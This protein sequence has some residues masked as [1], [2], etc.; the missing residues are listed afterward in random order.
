MK[1]INGLCWLLLIIGGLNWGFIAA[2]DFNVVQAIF[3]MG[4]I[5]TLIY[6][7]VGISA[8]YK[9]YACCCCGSKTCSRP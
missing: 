5:T 8:L 7:L 4:K 6:A 3:G 9:I 1:F 2:A